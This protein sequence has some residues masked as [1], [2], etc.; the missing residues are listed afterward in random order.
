MI[1]SSA[2][3][4]PVKLPI[5]PADPVVAARALAA[6][7]D[8]AVPLSLDVYIKWAVESGNIVNKGE[9]IAQLFYTFHGMPPPHLSNTMNLNN[10]SR[11]IRARLRRNDKVQDHQQE[12]SVQT[13]ANESNGSPKEDTVTAVEIRSPSNGILTVVFKNNF[14]SNAVRINQLGLYPELSAINLILAA[15]KPCEHPAV[16]GELCVVCGADMRPPRKMQPENGEINKSL[17]QMRDA[18]DVIQQDFV[19]DKEKK[20]AALTSTSA[21]LDREQGNDMFVNFDQ[22]AGTKPTPTTQVTTTRSLSSFLSGARA[23]NKLQ[24]NPKQSQDPC[25]HPRQNT[26]NMS[27]SAIDNYQ[28]IK[29]TVSGGVTIAVSESEAKNITEVSSRKLREEKKLCLVLDLDHTLLHATDDSRAGRFVAN[30]IISGSIASH[31]SKDENNAMMWNPTRM[32]NPEKRDDV[33]SI[34]LPVEMSP[35]QQKLY[36]QQ[37]LQQQQKLES[38]KFCLLPL[39]LHKQ[40]ASTCVTM[41]HFIKLRPHLKEF[42]SQIQS[43]YQLSV[44]TAGTRSYAEQIALMICRHLVGT[45]LDEDGLNELRMKVKE[46]EEECK[47]FDPGIWENLMK[48]SNKD[49]FM[50]NDS[51]GENPDNS[52]SFHDGPDHDSKSSSLSL[53]SKRNS[54]EV[55]TQIPKKLK[56]A[57]TPRS[58]L[59]EFMKERHDSMDDCLSASSVDPTKER[60]RLQKDLEVAEM[61]EIKAFE[62]RRKLFGSRIVSRTDVSDLGIG[63]KSLKRVFPCGGLMVRP[64]FIFFFYNYVDLSEL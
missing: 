64:W 29:M 59:Q 21:A 48:L 49:Y 20:I 63:V 11:I 23:T 10:G 38:T 12:A 35:I 42:F 4:I 9:K 5:P 46:N 27:S 15:I 61:L 1:S 37:K 55:E 13:Y 14:V 32:P 53:S 30:E 2:N 51:N 7:R 47:R 40:G 17:S 6:L 41:R 25:Q 45:K 36:V 26:L 57:E 43:S 33:R 56:G 60:F 39:P 54:S 3:A 58:N 22:F 62:L 8:E 52:L 16:V 28:M 24:D 44:Y 31:K 18:V 50:H 34:L 19:L